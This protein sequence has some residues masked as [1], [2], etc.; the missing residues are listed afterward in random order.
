MI[1]R[2]FCHEMYFANTILNNHKFSRFHRLV[3][4]DVVGD[5]SQRSVCCRWY[6]VVAEL[7]ATPPHMPTTTVVVRLLTAG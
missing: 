4:M 2:I 7:L 6:L 5:E 3:P 1:F